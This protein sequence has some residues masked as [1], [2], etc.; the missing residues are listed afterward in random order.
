MVDTSMRAPDASWIRWER[1]NALT[2]TQRHSFA[3]ICPEFVIELQ[4]ETDRLPV[5]REKMQM[6]IANGAELAW[7]IDPIAKTVEIYRPG[8]AV[9]MHEDPSSVLGDGPVN[10]FEPVMDRVWG[11]Q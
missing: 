10:G 8:E 2:E 4:S 5:L 11:G 6:W 7:L 1:W 3:P 9:E